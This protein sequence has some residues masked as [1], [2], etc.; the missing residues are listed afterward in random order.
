MSPAEVEL[1]VQRLVRLPYHRLI[2][3]DEVE[4]Y[5]GEIVELP[6]CFTA[7]ETPSQA[8]SNLDE[9]MAAWFEAAVK[10]GMAIPHPVDEPGTAFRGPT[11]RKGGPS[12]PADR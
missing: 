7:G 12:S 11:V 9:A 5:L 3:G 6:G 8:L 4:G 1:E 10:N 2:S